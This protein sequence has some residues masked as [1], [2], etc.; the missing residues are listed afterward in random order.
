[1]PI[2]D[3]EKIKKFSQMTGATLPKSIVGPMEKAATPEE[4]R[5][6]GMEF[7]TRQ[8]EDLRQNGVKYFHFY[9][10][11]QSRAVTEIVNNLGFTKK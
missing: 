3:I 10:M 5:K 6:L 11:N 9:T 8:C 7:A 4:A 2:T 1:M